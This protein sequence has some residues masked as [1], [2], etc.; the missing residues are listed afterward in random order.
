MKITSKAIG[1]ALACVL[2]GCAGA[3][4]TQQSQSVP[5]TAAKPSQI[6]VY[7]FAVNPNEVTLNQSILQRAYRNVSGEDQ[8]Q[9]QTTLAH[10]TAQSICQQVA[11][12]LGKKGYSASC[13]QRGSALPGANALVVDGQFTD[14]SEGNRLRRLVIG[15]GAGASKLDTNVQVF[16]LADTKS[17]EVL[18]FS[19]HADSG[20][21]PGAAV[22]GPAGAAAGGGAAAVVGANAAMGGAKTFTSATAYLAQKTA[23]QIVE[24]VEKYCTQQGWT[25]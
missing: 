17:N 19:T 5:V 7:P 12:S 25:P 23:D 2:A 21:M 4:V 16:H 15:F 3:A 24:S 11:A 20:K 10:D 8:S 18:G 9:Q 22:T 13:Q 14:L 1:A 6:V